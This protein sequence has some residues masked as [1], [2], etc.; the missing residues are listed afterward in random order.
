MLERFT[1]RARRVIVL[2][3]E[4]ARR[5]GHGAVGPEHLLLGILRDGE[6]MGV[7]LLDQF[8]VSREALQGATE[9]VLSTIPA[10]EAGASVAL[11]AELKAVLQTA[12]VIDDGHCRRHV[13]TEHLVGALLKDEESAAIR[14]LRS[15]GADVE[16][17]SRV[18]ALG[19]LMFKRPTDDSVRLI[20]TSKWRVRI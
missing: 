3:T 6:G 15:A 18:V 9:Q 17:T 19:R 2:A 13:A 8:K 10:A 7:R 4:E 16:R 14:I 1:G 20:A 11:A 12:L 5:R